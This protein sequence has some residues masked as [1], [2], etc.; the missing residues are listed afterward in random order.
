MAAS[1][2][3]DQRQGQKNAMTVIKVQGCDAERKMYKVLEMRGAQQS[4]LLAM[5]REI[6]QA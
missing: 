2:R 5:Y 1:E 4:D 6:L 3:P